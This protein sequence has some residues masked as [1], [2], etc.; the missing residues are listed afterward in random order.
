MAGMK[1]DTLMEQAQHM[2][3]VD[4]TRP[5]V[6]CRSFLTSSEH[7]Y[8]LASLAFVSSPDTIS[9]LK[10]FTYIVN[11]T[12]NRDILHLYCQRIEIKITFMN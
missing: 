3:C 12:T 9:E 2:G 6:P 8:L 7:H 11:K 10:S 5:S 4:T 1:G